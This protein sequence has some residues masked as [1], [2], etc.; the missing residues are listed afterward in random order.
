MNAWMNSPAA[1]R[2]EVLVQNFRVEADAA[3]PGHGGGLRVDAH[4]LE[5]AHI[6]PELE[7][8]DLEQVAEEHAALQPVVEPDPDG[9]RPPR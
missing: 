6:A 7:G 8:A 2:S 3:F 5:F 9:S 4:L 1:S